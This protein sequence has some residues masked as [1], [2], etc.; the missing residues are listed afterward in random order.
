MV[1]LIH[2]FGARK[3][4]RGASFKRVIDATLEVVGEVDE[5]PTGEVSDRQVIAIM[6]SP[7]MGFHGQLAL[8]T[9]LSADLGEVS[10]THAKVREGIPPEQI[11]SRL[12]KATSSLS[13]HSSPLLPDRLLL[14]SYIPPQG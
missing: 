2:N 6:D 11:A 9:V 8:E 1:D 13:G 7:E 14:N 5:H 12:D 3:R 10:L 4:K